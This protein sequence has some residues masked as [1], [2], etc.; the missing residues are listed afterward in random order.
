MC[1]YVS[2]VRHF[3]RAPAS[4]SLMVT[5]LTLIIA[6][7]RPPRSLQSAISRRPSTLLML[8]AIAM[9]VPTHRASGQQRYT[10]PSEP[11][12]HECTIVL[13]HVAS[14]GSGDDD[15]ILGITPFI[16]RDSRGNFYTVS[17][18]DRGAIYI[19]G[20]QGEFVKKIVPTSRGKRQLS[21][22]FALHVDA[23]D[24]I[25]IIDVAGGF[26]GVLSPT[27]ELVRVLPWVG[28]LNQNGAVFN[29]DGSVIVNA[30]VNTP[31][32]AGFPFHKLDQGGRVRKSFGPSAFAGLEQLNRQSVRRITSS[33]DGGIWTASPSE[34][35]LELWYPEANAPSVTLVRTAQWFPSHTGTEP[36]TPHRMPRPKIIAVQSTTRGH[37]WAITSV[38]D[39]RWRESLRK[40]ERETGDIYVPFQH[41]RVY[42]TIVEIIDPDCACLLASQR[43]DPFLAGF[44]DAEH[45]FS[46]RSATED[47]RVIYD[48][49][50]MRIRPHLK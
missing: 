3:C 44:A 34:Y 24:S 5:V 27:H 37:L 1:N 18:L 15:V 50:R 48:V 6:W 11:R 29:E 19:F 32:S 35:V 13:E 9:L 43:V 46:W 38:G 40:V 25:R 4:Y 23:S 28:R 36:L 49:W 31:E 16:R 8:L 2:Q 14:L 7:P 26:V 45:V 33:G 47:G 17:S 41:D 12:C 30:L 39:I 22:I 10:V 20:S 42:D 21:L